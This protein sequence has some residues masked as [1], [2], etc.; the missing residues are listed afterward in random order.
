MLQV[1]QEISGT[2][3]KRLVR[4][5][6]GVDFKRV[7]LS[8]ARIEELTKFEFFPTLPAEVKEKT[9]AASWGL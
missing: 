3:E 7:Q 5:H 9:D 6:D 1:G 2:P 4:I 8:T